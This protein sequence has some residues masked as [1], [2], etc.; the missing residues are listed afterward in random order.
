MAM[1]RDMDGKVERPA[2]GSKWKRG[3]IYSRGGTRETGPGT[4][5]PR[6]GRGE[7]GS[8]APEPP[9]TK[10]LRS[11][12][13]T[14]IPTPRPGRLPALLL[15]LA[16]LGLAGCG[17][18]DPS[19]PVDPDLEPLFG[20]WSAT[21]LVHTSRADP[22]RSLDLIQEGAT[23][24]LEIDTDGRYT[25]TLEFLGNT[26]P[27]RGFASVEGSELTLEPDGGTPSS[28]EFVLAGDMLTMDGLSNFDFP[29]DGEDVRVPT[30]LHIEFVKR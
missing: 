5:T 14:T 23:F 6:R 3:R 18:D 9:W 16:L 1:T 15:A 29:G 11:P 12:M 13:S 19:R 8:Q 2:E 4:L 28:A 7:N 20:E 27:E 17:E 24:T 30:D 22:S 10:D 21:A 26:F 25:A